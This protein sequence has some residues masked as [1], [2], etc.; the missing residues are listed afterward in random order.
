VSVTPTKRNYSIIYITQQVE[1]GYGS[2]SSLRRQGSAVSISSNTLS[3]TSSSSFRN[4]RGLKAKIAELETYRD[5]LVQQIETL[6]KYFDSCTAMSSL[7]NL[8]STG[9]GICLNYFTKLYNPFT[10]LVCDLCAFRAV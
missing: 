3:T 1:S 8:K 2:E 5:I 4:G 6:Q 10:D 7:H 9:A